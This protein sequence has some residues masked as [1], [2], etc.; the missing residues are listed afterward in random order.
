MTF[1]QGWSV[2]LHN[3]CSVA[4]IL[5][6]IE[7]LPANHLQ[8][9]F[10]LNL[11]IIYIY[12]YGSRH[13]GNG[14]WARIPISCKHVSSWCVF[15]DLHLASDHTPLMLHIHLTKIIHQIRSTYP[16]LSSSL[17]G[18]PMELSVSEPIKNDYSI[19]PW[20]HKFFFSV[21][22]YN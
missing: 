15:L 7:L 8:D 6:V 14:F 11:L 21:S 12:I 18:S 5:P 19:S 1:D 20:Q 3:P 16:I 4:S 13:P 10:A 22:I 17:S 9:Y 2:V